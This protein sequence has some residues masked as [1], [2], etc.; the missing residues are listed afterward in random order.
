VGSG[1]DAGLVRT[2][3][4]VEDTLREASRRPPGVPQSWVRAG[5][6]DLPATVLLGALSGLTSFHPRA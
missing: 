2:L 6:L 4:A 5:V 3:P 1:A